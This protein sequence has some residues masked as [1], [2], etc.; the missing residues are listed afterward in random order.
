MKTIS[1]FI[2]I[3][4]LLLKSAIS[5]THFIPLMVD[6]ACFKSQPSRNYVEIYAS[7]FQKDLSY[8]PFS[9]KFKARYLLTAQV[10]QGD[11]IIEQQSK[12]T[13]SIVDSLPEIT[14]DKQFVSLFAFELPGGR[15]QAKIMIEDINSGGRGEYLCEL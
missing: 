6:H 10:Q 13:E 1:N 15:Y 2:L 11:S 14:A 8:L 5:Q 4:F 12:Q 3:L 7:L 9:E